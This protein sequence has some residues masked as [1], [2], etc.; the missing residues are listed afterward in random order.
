MLTLI[1]CLPVTAL[2]KDSVG[3]GVTMIGILTGLGS[4]LG[5]ALYSIF[6]R[7][8][9]KKYDSL[10]VTLYTFIF[11]TIGLIPIT[12]I[13][14]VFHLLSNPH[15]LYY[16]IAL[17]I[18]ATAFPFLLYTIGLN[19]LET[20]KASIIATLEPIV[21][22]IIGIM[23]Y[24]EPITLFKVLGISIVILAISILREKNAAVAEGEIKM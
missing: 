21:A 13:R 1:G 12:G 5:Y 7:Y 17:G 24:K 22:T 14:E 23:L 19:Y 3:Q 4:V 15:A 20:S 18:M 9:L 6:G 2:V 8:A 11:A 16:S 10:T